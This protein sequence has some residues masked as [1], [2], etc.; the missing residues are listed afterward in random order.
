MNGNGDLDMILLKINENGD[1][2]WTKVFGSE[3]ASADIGNTVIQTPDNGYLVA[4]ATGSFDLTNSDDPEMLCVVKTDAKGFTEWNKVYSDH[5]RMDASDIDSTKGGYVVCGTTNNTPTG[6]E[7][8]LLMKI[9]PQGDTVWQKNLS[10]TP[11]SDNGLTVTS[12]AGGYLV[13]GTTRDSLDNQDIVVIK[14]DELGN[15]VWRKIFGNK[16][17]DDFA[18]LEAIKSGGYIIAGS[19]YNSTAAGNKFMLIKIDN[20]GNTV[21]TQTY[22]ADKNETAHSVTIAPDGGFVIAGVKDGDSR[23]YMY[24]MKVD[25]NG[26]AQPA[27]P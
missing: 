14:T 19:A 15:I 6:K 12:V 7:G 26:N 2:L 16:E 4:G 27:K 8:I 5:G 22:P 9:T 24:V 3:D 21:W 10:N 1:T 18:G 25:A 11:N 23:S 13:A 17:P 20:A